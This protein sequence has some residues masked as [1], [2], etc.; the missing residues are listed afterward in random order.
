[1]AIEGRAAW[2]GGSPWRSSDRFM[3]VETVHRAVVVLREGHRGLVAQPG[4]DFAPA[5][6]GK[7]VAGGVESARAL[8]DRVVGGE[9]RAKLVEEARRRRPHQERRE[10]PVI[11]TQAL[12]DRQRLAAATGSREG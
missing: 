11:R 5:V 12:G 4:N 3:S 10:G 8:L 1:M 6:A 7:G 9:R 2:S